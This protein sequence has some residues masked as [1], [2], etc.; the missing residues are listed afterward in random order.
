MKQQSIIYSI[1]N[2]L[3]MT[4][5]ITS[6]FAIIPR[7][8]LCNVGP[9]SDNGTTSHQINIQDSLIPDTLHYGRFSLEIKY[10]PGYIVKTNHQQDIAGSYIITAIVDS[11]NLALTMTKSLGQET[12]FSQSNITEAEI[13][14]LIFDDRNTEMNM[15]G[16]ITDEEIV[17]GVYFDK[18]GYEIKD[19]VKIHERII[20]I[21]KYSLHILY[22]N[23]R[24]EQLQLFDK[25]LNN[26]KIFDF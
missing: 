11:V 3:I 21:P 7:I 16:T 5:A 9:L 22:Q 10:P 24:D 19:N 6:V 23:V 15:N 1:M 18:R 8:A 20:S 12:D 13:F 26:I 25:I 4:L 14:I 2:K 17:S